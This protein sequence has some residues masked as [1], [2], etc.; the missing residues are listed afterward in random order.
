MAR[1]QYLLGLDFGTDSVRAVVVN[2]ASGKEEANQVARY[3]RWGQGLYCDPARNRFRQHP[4]DYVD[5]LEEAAR[6]AL[7]QLPKGAGERVLGI[8]IDTTGSTPCAVDRA[9]T[10]L[11]LLPEFRENPNAM[12]VLWK[13]HSAV[14]EA[15][16]INR[17]ARSWGGTDFTKYEGGIYSSEWFFAKILRILRDD[18]AVAKAAYSWVEHCDWMPALLTG[19][20]DPLTLK[21]SRCAAGH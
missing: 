15:E 12:F 7:A 21:R 9:G 3:R 14:Q 20:A 11:A 4:Q 2:A 17:A 1:A 6:G 18:P 8:G 19:S 13:D 5:G 10:P 16:Q